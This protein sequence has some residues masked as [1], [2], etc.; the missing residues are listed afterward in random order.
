ML[1]VQSLLAL[2][3]SGCIVPDA[4]SYDPP[5]TTAPLLDAFNAIP[6]N[7]YPVLV[8]VAAAQVEF[9][10]PVRS[11]DAGDELWVGVYFDYG[12]SKQLLH[13][14]TD[15]S[16]STLDDPERSIKFQ[17]RATPLVGCHTLTLLVTHRANTFRLPSGERAPDL[18]KA[19]G[20]LGV[21]TWFLNFQPNESE[22]T[23]LPLCPNR[24]EGP[25]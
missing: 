12:T 4:P 17:L 24:A 19:A 5:G 6:S 20:D 9:D 2:L 14:D 3:A 13:T 15:V 16:A 22:P 18:Q 11:E 1:S 25:T 10:V 23:T 7:I 21:A 8:P